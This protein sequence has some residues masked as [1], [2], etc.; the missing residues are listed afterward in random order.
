MRENEAM[1][2]QESMRRAENGQSFGNYPAIFEGFEKMGVPTGDIVPRE[3]V[4]T[5]EIWHAKGRQV[6]KGEHG[7]RIVTYREY[8]KDGEKKK[9]PKPCTVFHISQTET[10]DPEGG[11]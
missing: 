1:E 4:F 9:A 11:E 6:I 8:V 2:V 3:N 5:Y 7:V 10:I